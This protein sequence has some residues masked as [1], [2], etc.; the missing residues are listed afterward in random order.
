MDRDL[1]TNE[2]QSNRNKGGKRIKEVKR[3]IQGNNQKLL[4][5]FVLRSQVTFDHQNPL[6]SSLSPSGCLY[7]I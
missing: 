5:K 2:T 6:S 3:T 4:K 1:L 7:Q